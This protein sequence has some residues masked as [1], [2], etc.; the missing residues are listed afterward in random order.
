[1]TGNND[2]EKPT[3]F[4]EG[5]FQSI[6]GESLLASSNS[7]RS[8]QRTPREQVAFEIGQ[9]LKSYKKAALALLADDGYSEFIDLVPL[10]LKVPSHIYVVHCNDGIFVR[11]DQLKEGETPQIRTAE[12]QS[13]ISWFTPNF[14]EQVVHICDDPTTFVPPK[15]G[16]RLDIGMIDFATGE[17]KSQITIHPVVLVTT[18]DQTKL[19][20]K[21]ITNRPVCLAAAVCETEI[22][23]QGHL[24]PSQEHSE[25]MTNWFAHSA[26]RMPVGWLAIEIYPV[27][28]SDTWN[29]QIAPMWAEMDIL[30]AVAR[31]N[32]TKESL[33][34]IDSRGA[35][36]KQYK[37]ILDEFISLLGGK[38]EPVHQYLKKH[39]EL[40]FPTAAQTWSKLR[41]G[42]N[43]SDFVFRESYN[44]YVLVEI[45]APIRELFRKDGQQ[46]EELT[47]AINQIADWVQYIGDNKAVV[48]NQMGLTGISVTPRSMVV[49]GRSEMLTEENR[50][51][52]AVM[53]NANPRLR[54]LTYDDVLT[55]CKSNLERILGPLDFEA[56]N[57]ELYFF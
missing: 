35:T 12:H 52:L 48:E 26:L 39:P 30:A 24:A 23:M 38:E 20:L 16:P 41:F 45:E 43:I 53:Q 13:D 31:K 40:L 9:A 22:G 33:L 54:I 8:R 49:I 17:K 10:H 25:E 32:S 46:R 56:C 29:E 19:K 37:A 2:A 42:K 47:H 4:V 1:M 50:K 27:P 34:N 15:T 57:M 55:N 51:K 44:D 11:Y 36:R 18:P 5:T 6:P 21:T 3:N 7:S 14:S 28:E